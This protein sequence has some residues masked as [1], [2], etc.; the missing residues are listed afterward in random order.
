[1]K[2]SSN[3]LLAGALIVGT[4]ACVALLPWSRWLAVE[5][6]PEQQLT[7]RIA[8][9]AELRQQADWVE[10]YALMDEKDRN[11]VPLARFMGLYGSSPLKVIS[12][13]E[14]S[15]KIDMAAGKAET[16]LKLEAELQLDK[17]PL[18]YRR[19]LGPQ[20]PEDLR[21]TDDFSVTWVWADDE[22]WLRMDDEARTGRTKDGKAV[23]P[24]VGP[25]PKAGN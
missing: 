23:K 21:K 18:Q 2:N 24:T 20:K 4:G 15:R 5:P 1:M 19:S 7:E 3:K 17:L 10:I 13:T 6:D 14:N 22:W 25:Q 9:Y 8:R 16:N 11:K 12:I